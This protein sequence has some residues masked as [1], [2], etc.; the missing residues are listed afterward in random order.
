MG[1]AIKLPVGFLQELK[2]LCDTYNTL[3][4]IDEVF[5][6]YGRTGKMFAFEHENEFYELIHDVITDEEATKEHETYKL[7]KSALAKL[8]PEERIALDL[9]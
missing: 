2:N 9:K 4:I 8:T 7:R 1:G 6:G 3:M 5:T